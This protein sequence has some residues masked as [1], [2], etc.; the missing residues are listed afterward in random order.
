MV[1]RMTNR[2][3]AFADSG[4][5]PKAVEMQKRIKEEKAVRERQRLGIQVQDRGEGVLGEVERKRKEEEQKGLLEKIWMGS[6]GE[7]WKA[8]RDRRE[9]E[10]LEEGRGY[11][12]LIMDQIWEVWN[13]GKDKN[14]Q[15]KE[16]DEKVVAERKAKDEEKKR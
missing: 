4:L 11:G 7:D 6:E 3:N 9:K 14:E 15:V 10:A 16:I 13:W 1:E 2:A 12:G 5:P 8:K